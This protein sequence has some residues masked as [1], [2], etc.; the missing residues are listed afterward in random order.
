MRDAS[1]PLDHTGPR[2]IKHKEVQEAKPE[3]KK[4]N[5][6]MP[7]LPIHYLIFAYT[8]QKKNMFLSF[9]CRCFPW[10]C[11]GFVVVVTLEWHTNNHKYMVQGVILSNKQKAG[12]CCIHPAL[13]MLC[14]FILVEMFVGDLYCFHCEDACAKYA[15]PSVWAKLAR[16]RQTLGPWHPQDST[17]AGFC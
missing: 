1:Y 10:F 14:Q 12:G 9:S 8:P 2:I 3:K 4:K 16:G 5:I 13:E 11:A 7:L 15:M 17:F 6:L